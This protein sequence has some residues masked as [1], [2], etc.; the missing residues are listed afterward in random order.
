M[1][2]SREKAWLLMSVGKVI[3]RNDEV[4]HSWKHGC[5]PCLSKILYKHPQTD[6]HRVFQPDGY[7]LEES[8]SHV[9]ERHDSSHTSLEIFYCTKTLSLFHVGNEG[10]NLACAI[11]MKKQQNN[12]HDVSLQYCFPETSRKLGACSLYNCW[13]DDWSS[14]TPQMCHYFVI[15]LVT[16]HV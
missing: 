11:T 5:L 2:N 3:Y 16:T 9:L 6:P 10:N 15:L 8:Q 7:G 4:W 14:R 1:W 12:S 13:P